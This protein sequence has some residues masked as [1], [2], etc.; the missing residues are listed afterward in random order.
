MLLY[1]AEPLEVE[2]FDHWPMVSADGAD[3]DERPL[4]L[5][6]IVR[7]TEIVAVT[8]VGTIPKLFSY[9]NK[10][11]ANLDAQREGASKESATYGATR[12]PKP[13]NPLSAVAN[14]MIHEA[15][16]KFK[17]VDIGLSCLI[18]Q[19]MSL[20][21]DLLRLVVFPRTMA[22][23]EMA[24][25]V[26]TEVQARL[27]RIIQSDGNPG[28]RDLHLSFS[29]ITISKFNQLNHSATGSASPSDGKTWLN[30]LLKDA[31]EAIIVGLPSMHMHMLSEEEG[32]ELSKVLVYDFHSKFIRREGMKNFEDIFITLNVSLYSWLTLLRKNLS[33]EMSQVQTTAAAPT[34][35]ATL[36]KKAPER[37]QAADVTRQE[38]LTLASV[39]G[40]NRET[41]SPPPISPMSPSFP[42]A[43]PAMDKAKSTSPVPP[44][45]VR[46]DEQATDTG[47]ASSSTTSE[48]KS[49]TGIMYRPRSRNIERLTMRQLGEATPDVMHPFFTKKAG[50][51]LEDSLPQYVNE[52]ATIPLEKIMEVLLKLYNKQL[53][54]RNS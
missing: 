45:M 19:H 13:D 3:V 31:P 47:G 10:F 8:T 35:I 24:Q 21:L 30:L 32:E 16:T 18:L 23:V 37:L 9:A 39:D 27:D 52:Y 36:R 40:K 44:P 33:R 51:N 12:S 50:F 42:I 7:S 14:A 46:T 6:F 43:A 49:T 29:S 17:E 1:S 26:V 5:S 38:S 20:H 11:K 34:F 22:D 28:N 25:F 54:S 4:R 15:R 2:I 48:K 41:L 53:T